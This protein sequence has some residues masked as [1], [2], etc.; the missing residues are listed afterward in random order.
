MCIRDRAVTVD[1]ESVDW[2]MGPEQPFIGQPLSIP[3]NG[4]SQRISIQYASATSAGA[5]L[6]VE[7]EQPF[8]LTQSQAILARTW[9]PCQD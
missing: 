9:I 4:N 8:L 3:V 2:Y 7:G 5:L 1:G 6:W